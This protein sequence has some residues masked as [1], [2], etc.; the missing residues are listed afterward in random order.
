MMVLILAPA[1]LAI[2]FSFFIS[3]RTAASFRRGLVLNVTLPREQAVDVRVQELVAGYKKHNLLLLPLTLALGIPLLLPIPPSLTIVGFFVLI[4][5]A[6]LFGNLNLAKYSTKLAALKRQEGWF[7]GETETI[8][9][10]LLTERIRGMGPVSG[11]WF[12]PPLAITLALFGWAAAHRGSFSPV[13]YSASGLVFYFSAWYL[14]QTSV[15]EWTLT[16]AGL[17]N[18][19]G[20]IVLFAFLLLPHGQTSVLGL[21]LFLE[22]FFIF[23][24]VVWTRS[25]LRHGRAHIL[26]AAAGSTITVDQ[27]YYWRGGIYSNPHDERLLVAQRVGYGATLNFGTRRGKALGVLIFGAAVAGLL[28]LLFMFAA[29]DHAHYEL[30]IAEELITI[31]APFYGFSFTRDELKSVAILEDLPSGMRTNGAETRQ[32]SLGNYIMRGYG[33]SKVYIHKG[34]PP[35]LVLELAHLHVFFNGE[36]AEQTK[37]HYAELQAVL[38][39]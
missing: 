16:W 2:V 38:G 17:A 27:D 30:R 24:A 19:H 15:R 35:Y 12:V 34:K 4:G 6:S 33:K 21:M 11:L 1:V 18:L 29:F 3:F 22:L 26:A 13:I 10:D 32:Y 37:Q 31:T 9:V 36:T 5:S 25:I 28:F 7:V 23:A 8:D 39:R 14:A 20:A